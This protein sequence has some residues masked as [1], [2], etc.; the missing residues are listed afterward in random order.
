MHI[1]ISVK[2]WGLPPQPGKSEKAGKILKTWLFP[3]KSGFQNPET[4]RKKVGNYPE[5]PESWARYQNAL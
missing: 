4:T 2:L 1:P 3:F 5:N